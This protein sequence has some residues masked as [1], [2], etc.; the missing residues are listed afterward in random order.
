[1]TC[2]PLFAKAVRENL[3]DA[4]VSVDHFH[5]F[6]LAPRHAHQVRQLVSREQNGRR[7]LKTGKA[8]AH[9]LLL[10]RGY[11]PLSSAGKKPLP[12]G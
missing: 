8:W 11:D 6:Q 12:F 7:G 3:L 10:L 2:S 5:V 1:M 4:A 9:R